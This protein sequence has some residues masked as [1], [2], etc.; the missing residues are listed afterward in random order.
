MA[1]A[2]LDSSSKLISRGDSPAQ[3][4]RIVAELPYK[5]VE[6][7][8]RQARRAG[9]LWELTRAHGLSL[10]DRCC[11]ALAEQVGLPVLTKGS[12]WSKLSIGIEIRL[13]GAPRRK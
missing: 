11:L 8:Q 2:V 5:A 9:T 12:I 3:A 10:G 7:D 13:I 1:Q 6:V 4:Q